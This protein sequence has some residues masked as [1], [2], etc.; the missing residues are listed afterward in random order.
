MR[1]GIIGC[2]IIAQH[3]M[4]E[5]NRID[6]AEMVAFC[7]V[8][9]AA[10]EA[11]ALKFGPGDV[12]SNIQDV[13]GRNDIDAV[14]ICLHNNL[15]M[16]ATVAALRAGKH[17]YCEKP[18]AGS[19]RDAVTM[20]ETAKETGKKL[21]IQLATLYSNET[22]AARE[23]IEGGHLGDVYHA[24]SSGFRRRGRPYVD[25]YGTP[26]FVQKKQASGG[27]LYDMGVYHISQILYL[28]GNPKVERV[29]GKTYQR[30]DMD[31]NRRSISNY[32]VEEMASGFVRFEGDRSMELTE[33]WAANLDNFDGSFLLGSKGGIRLSPFGFFTNIGN[34]E[35]KATADL[36]SAR[37]RWDT[38][39]GDGP[40]YGSSQGHWIAAL[41]GKA[42]LLP[43]AEVAL[44]T[45]LISEAIYLSQERGREVTADEVL[46]ASVSKAIGL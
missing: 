14:D 10:A 42:P 38:V 40:V 35:M 46:E 13:L 26:A 32:D 20:L 39:V 8:N 36:G 43:T 27:A 16:P 17:V 4:E 41:E 5:Y 1:I 21:H 11:A 29:T 44:N 34:L 15:H 19:Y 7:D 45:M 22:R 6:G 31:A 2:G 23:L 30:I 25:G 12:T 18:M 24:R 9:K 37:F 33:S 3:H 28:L